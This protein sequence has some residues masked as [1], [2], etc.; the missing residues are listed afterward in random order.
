MERD[1]FLDRVRRASGSAAIPPFEAEAPLPVELEGDLLDR[2]RERAAGV[3]V[4]V[5]DVVTANDAR[6]AVRGI[7]EAAGAG[8]FC[9][10]DDEEMPVH[11]IGPYLAI[12][13]LIEHVV[14]GATVGSLAP[15]DLGLTS[16]EALLAETGSLVLTTGPGRPRLASVI[17]AVH[18]AVVPTDR[19]L[20]SLRSW[21]DDTVGADTANTVV[22]TGP[23]RTADIEGVLVRGVHGPGEVHVVLVG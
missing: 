21:L 23:S 10:W 18:V 1:A 8:A 19:V 3:G 20:P 15:V 16:A 9:A 6:E 5:H 7:A 4:Q 12:A 22:I 2:W 17:G 11:G 14:E 13:G